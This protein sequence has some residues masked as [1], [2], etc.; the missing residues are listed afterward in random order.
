MPAH[1]KAI[2]AAITMVFGLI[3]PTHADAP[4]QGVTI[5]TFEIKMNLA[6]GRPAAGYGLITGPQG[7]SLRSVSS[8]EAGRVELHIIEREGNVAK[9]MRVDH[10]D[11]DEDGQLA[12]KR[13]AN[14]LMLFNVADEAANDGV[15]PLTFTF[16]D[17]ETQTFEAKIK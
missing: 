8:P 4:S 5:E 13:G 14:H 3:S 11:V 1:P 6:P 9:M 15:I 12:F 16:A 17:G 10:L 7:T 2:L